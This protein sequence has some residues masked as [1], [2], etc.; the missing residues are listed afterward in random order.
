MDEQNK[1]DE[2]Q[3]E[4]KV[5]PAPSMPLKTIPDLITAHEW[6]FNAQRNGLI[7]G[8]TADGL[9]TTLKGVNY[10][11]AKLPMDAAKLMVQ[12]KIKKIDIPDGLLPAS[13]A[14]SVKEDKK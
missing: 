2:Q 1:N 11:R 10:L 4:R 6:L 14:D 7:D 13:I 3:N 12:A 9:N 5:T 8:K